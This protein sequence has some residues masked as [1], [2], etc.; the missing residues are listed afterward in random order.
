MGRASSFNKHNVQQFFSKYAEVL[1]RYKFQPSR[2]YNLDKTGVQTVL[3]P[4][5][6]VAKKGSKQVGAIVSAERGTLVTVELAV[7]A[8]GLGNCVP[9]MFVF[10]SLKYKDLFIQCGPPQSIG[11]GNGSGWMTAAEFSLYL[12]HFIQYTKPPCT[13]PVL[14][15]LNNHLTH[16]RAMLGLDQ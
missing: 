10:P 2:I 11:P 9:P 5:K 4:R 6:I 8:L 7:N 12:D 3:K 1:D 13:D 14:L 15:L 16:K